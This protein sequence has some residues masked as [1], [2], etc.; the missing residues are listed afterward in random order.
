MGE[1]DD[2]KKHIFREHNQE[3]DHLA[4][5]GTEG[6]MKITIEG[7][8]NTEKWKAVRGYWDGSKKIDGRSGC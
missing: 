8:K 5:L 6:K 1:I 2:C 7:V 4:H 3:A